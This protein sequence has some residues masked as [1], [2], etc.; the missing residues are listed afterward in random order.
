MD[1]TLPSKNQSIKKLI[2]EKYDGNVCAFCRALGIKDSQKINRLFKID[3]RSG[4]YPIPSTKII[5]LISNKLEISVDELFGVHQSNIFGDN[6]Y[7]NNVV[8]NG[9]DK[10]LIGK[11]LDEISEQRKLAQTSQENLTAALNILKDKLK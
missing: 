4:K 3:K 9:L 8:N 1:E 7:K 2:Q 11:F 5:E 6:H 10:E